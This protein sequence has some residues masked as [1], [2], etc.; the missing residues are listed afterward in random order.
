MEREIKFRGKRI[1]NGE[2]VYGD[3]FRH[4]E[5]DKLCWY[6]G[7]MENEVD[8]KTVG[9]YMNIEDFNGLGY[10]EGDIVIKMSEDFSVTDE[11]P[12]DDPRWSVPN[13]KLPLKEVMRDVATMDSFP[14][15]WLKNESFGYE[16]ENLETPSQ[17]K[18][19]G[20]IHENQL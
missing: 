19:I 8:P 20:N 15:Y 18:I 1:D 2:W 9:Q 7:G 13:F 14:V 16:G 11:W 5:E 10:Y 12:E 6:V 17:C 4:H 3:L